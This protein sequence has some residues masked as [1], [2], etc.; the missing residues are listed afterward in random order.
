VDSRGDVA[1]AA[2][3]VLAQGVAQL[4]PERA[5]FDGMLAGWCAQQRSRMLNEVTIGGRERLVR[6]FAEFTNEYPWSWRAQDVEGFTTSLR[7]GGL[8]HSTIRGYHDILE[9]FG[10]FVSDRRYGWVEEC[11]RRFGRAPAVICHEWNTAAHA[12]AFEA[13]PGRRALTTGELQRFFDHADDQV[14][15]VAGSGRKGT[16]AAFRDAAM[17]KVVYAWGL[18]RREAVMLDVA[19]LHRNAQAPQFG[20]YGALHVR[21]GKASR[22]SPPK[23]RTVLSVHDWAVDALRQYVEEIRDGF[24]PG[25]HPAL[26]VT[27]RRSRVS[28]RQVNARF[29][30]YR[31][32][33]GLPGELDLHSLRHSYVTH[34]IETGFPER[35]VTDQ[36][37][38]AYAATTAIYTGVSDD[39]KSRVLAKAL[40]GGFGVTG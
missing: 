9:L 25:Q 29:A 20:S 5:M 2:H 11:E 17:F 4:D 28:V 32:A 19:D 33:A 36:V 1:G 3:L 40:A 38:H 15:R 7:S 8:A 18:R 16:L 30:A 13:R 34:L 27:E 12:S 21:Y 10:E 14:D 23:R 31:D 24:D 26:W 35:F 22:G 37:G 39:Y 6:R